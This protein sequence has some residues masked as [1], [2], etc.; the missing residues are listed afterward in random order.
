VPLSVASPSV[1]PSP[2]RWRVG[3]RDFAFEACSG[4][5]HVT[6]RRVAQLPKAAFVTRL[7]PDR[8]PSRAARQL[9]DLP[10]ILWVDPPSTGHPRLFGAHSEIR[11]SCRT[12]ADVGA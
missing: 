6:A 5:T 8:S 11:D 9:P 12:V 3:I 2:L 4:F 10:T 1:Q 7:R